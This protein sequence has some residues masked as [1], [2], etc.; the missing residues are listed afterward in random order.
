MKHTQ[1]IILLGLIFVSYLTLEA[2]ASLQTV[3]AL[4][5]G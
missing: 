1:K 2:H 3:D 4:F 5:P